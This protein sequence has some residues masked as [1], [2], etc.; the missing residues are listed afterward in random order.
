MCNFKT[1]KDSE[2]RF[3]PEDASWEIKVWLKFLNGIKTEVFN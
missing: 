2:G 1:A 3:S